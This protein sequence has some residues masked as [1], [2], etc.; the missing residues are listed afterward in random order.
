MKKKAYCISYIFVLLIILIPVNVN[1]NIVCKDGTVSPSCNDCHRGCCSKHGGCTNASSGSSS[2]SSGTTNNSSSN[3]S[4]SGTT[5]TINNNNSSSNSN[6]ST[7]QPS[8]K[9]DPKSNDVSLKE[10][11]IDDESID[12]SDSMSYTT[13]KE[14]VSIYT[15]SND[16]KAIIE[17]NK[18]AKLNI[19]DNTINI[20]VTAENGDIK[21]YI[22]NIIR[23]KIASNNKNIKIIIDDK[24]VVFNS[25][26]SEVIY[27]SNNKNKIDI[28]YEL[29]DN[30]ARV[31]ITGNENL[32]VGQNEVIVKVIAENGEEQDYIIMIEKYSKVTEFVFNII[33]AAI[34]I[35]YF[36]GIGYLIYYLLKKKKKIRI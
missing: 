26:K 3:N 27:I 16:N 33:V 29:E 18:S 14:T 4:V 11:T 24:D 25:F 19:G 12:I 9:E 17:Y 1:A 5:G 23:E 13:S 21:E 20:K 32:K 15:A 36:G 35:G 22:L 6:N 2:S 30:N 28:K 10:V 8:I 34:I 31:E 7:Q